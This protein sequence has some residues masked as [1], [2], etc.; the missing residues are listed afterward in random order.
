M[1]L[2]K[3]IKNSYIPASYDVTK[4]EFYEEMAIELCLLRNPIYS[5][6]AYWYPWLLHVRESLSYIH[7][8]CLKRTRIFKQ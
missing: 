3:L 1:S 2:I 6:T 7:L 5:G 4:D 8:D